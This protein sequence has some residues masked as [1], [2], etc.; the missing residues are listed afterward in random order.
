[1]PGEDFAF[2]LR[3]LPGSFMFIGIRNES[4]GSVHNLHS[5]SFKLDEGV[6]PLGAALHASL[7][8]EYLAS[9]GSG[10]GGAEG[11]GGGSGRD[12]L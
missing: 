11:G 3:K 10:F 5:P 8:A 4:L 12:E 7:A 1:M 2:F 9:H 6:L